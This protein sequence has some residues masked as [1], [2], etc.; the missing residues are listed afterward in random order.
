MALRRAYHDGLRPRE[1]WAK[2]TS[3]TLRRRVQARVARRSFTVSVTAM[4]LPY[5]PGLVL[6]IDI[7]HCTRLF[8]PNAPDYKRLER[9]LNRFMTTG[10]RETLHSRFPWVNTADREKATINARR[11]LSAFLGGRWAAKEA[12]KKAW[13]AHLVG[14]RNVVVEAH[15][16]RP[17]SILCFATEGWASDEE[18]VTAQAGTLSL[19][20]DGSY[21]FATVIAEA[22]HPDLLAEFLKQKSEAEK[23]VN[24]SPRVNSECEGLHKPFPVP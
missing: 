16:E 7:C 23:Q 10:E 15:R 22:L 20:H 21:A 9:L 18:R 19:T 2:V 4:L 8:D 24:G 12:A 5:R 14:F 17:P 11:G 13:G 1:W 3:R 6:G